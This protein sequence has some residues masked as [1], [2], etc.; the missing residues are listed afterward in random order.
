MKRAGWAESCLRLVCGNPWNKREIG[1]DKT[2]ETRREY[3]NPATYS[4]FIF[5]FRYSLKEWSDDRPETFY[6]CAKLSESVPEDR[7]RREYFTSETAG[8]LY[9]KACWAEAKNWKEIGF[10]IKPTGARLKISAPQIILF[11]FPFNQEDR[12]DQADGNLLQTG[13]LAVE[14]WFEEPAGKDDHRPDLH[15]LMSFNEFFRYFQRPFPGHE[16]GFTDFF[17]KMPVSF[18]DDS[19]GTVGKDKADIKSCYL[20]RWLSMLRIPLLVETERGS[21]Y[22]RFLPEKEWAVYADNR[23]FVWSCAVIK[24]GVGALSKAFNKPVARPEEFGHWV[25]FLNVDRPGK[26]FITT[27]HGTG[28]YERQWAK[29]RTYTRWLH[30]GTAYGFNYHSGVMIADPP[31]KNDVPVWVHFGAMYFDQVLLLFYIRISLFRFSRELSKRTIELRNDSKRKGDDDRHRAEEYKTFADLREKIVEFTNLYQFP[32]ISNQ[33]QGIEMFKLARR[34]LEIDDLYR[35]INEQ[36]SRVHEFMELNAAHRFNEIAHNI[37][38][39]GLVISFMA[40]SIG[41]LSI[42]NL[43][44]ES[45]WNCWSGDGGCKPWWGV[46]LPILLIVLLA[47]MTGIATWFVFI[48]KGFKKNYLKRPK[49][50]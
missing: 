7:A 6:K 43:L 12:R 37:A 14:A 33:Q 29:E 34:Y 2:G 40:L 27:H 10:T 1:D 38:K 22:F 3:D 39:W 30:Y 46:I 20:E 25:K 47:G 41:F 26:T 5:P 48:K 13:M 32:L 45:M 11:E 19:L 17:T 35:D 24:K 8:V 28:E 9:D 21:E 42:N 31:G 23:A 18:T 36:V 44:P 4:R 49:R 50:R 15:D 16:K